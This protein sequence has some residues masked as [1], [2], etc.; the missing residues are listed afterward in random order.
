MPRRAL[1]AYNIFFSEQREKILEE[2]DLKRQKGK[3]KEESNDDVDK[4]EKEEGNSTVVE[5]SKPKKDGRDYA[6]EDEF[7]SAKMKSSLEKEDEEEDHESKQERKGG[8]T[9][10]ERT[11]GEAKEENEEKGENKKSKSKK[12]NEENEGDNEEVDSGPTVMTRSFFPA[13]TKR[14]HRK[15]HG[16]IGLVELAREVSKR[17]KV[18]DPESRSHY[19]GLAEED[20]KRH[21]QVMA[22]YHQ[23]KAAENMVNMGRRE[24]KTD[25][26]EDEGEGSK[27]DIRET[28]THHHQQ[29]IVAEMVA[30]QAHTEDPM[31]TM[32]TFS[33]SMGISS[34]FRD[35]NMNPMQ[36]GGMQRMRISGVGGMGTDMSGR[37]G[38]D[39]GD[40]GD[41]SGMGGGSSGGVGGGTG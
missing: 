28:I 25:E 39:M 3:M 24:Y 30:R 27:N 17:W 23:M 35:G 26:K 32:G 29:R 37:S 11:K 4:E 15:V 7:N 1:S 41:R 14:V 16:K 22:E 34:R 33:P 5:E 19:D 18:L 36:G 38:M 13:K 2:I 21:K 8:K 20:R 31:L 10:K 9:K 12:C 6:D 40:S